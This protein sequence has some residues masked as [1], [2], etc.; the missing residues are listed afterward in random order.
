MRGKNRRRLRRKLSALFLLVFLMFAILLISMLISG[1][2]SFFLFELNIIHTAPENRHILLVGCMLLVSLVMGTVLARAGG[3]RFLRQFYALFDAMKEVA[4][5]NF[6]VR[7][8]AGPAR[9]TINLAKNFNEMVKELSNIETLRADFVSSISH[10]FRTPVA[11]IRGFARRLKK[12]TLTEEQRNECIDIIISESERL[13]RLSSNVL[14]LSSLES[15][16]RVTEQAEYPL[17]EQLRRTLLLLQPQLQK[18]GIVIDLDLEEVNITAS[19]ELLSHLWINLLGN[20]IK[21]SPDGGAIKVALWVSGDD[22][23][24]SIADEGAGMG[25]DVKR[26]IFDK[27]YQGD[28]ARATEG[29][30]LGLSLVKRVLELENGRIE[31]DSEPGK[32]ACFIVSLPIRPIAE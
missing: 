8:E 28:G 6:S 24:V 21:F 20:A 19:D 9:E 13:T 5:G 17:D 7:M 27:F 4:A 32:G 26:R 18:K 23:V 25:H 14:L 30:G 15:T 12:G 10:E 2:V 1:I 22:A 11:S 16:E 3:R 29:N 31:V